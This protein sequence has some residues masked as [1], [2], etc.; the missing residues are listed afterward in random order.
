MSFLYWLYVSADLRNRGERKRS[1]NWPIWDRRLCL[2]FL[3]VLFTLLALFRL[4]DK[5]CEIPR[6]RA[7]TRTESKSWWY[8]TLEP[9]IFTGFSVCAQPRRNMQIHLCRSTHHSCKLSKLSVFLVFLNFS[10]YRSIPT[11]AIR[12]NSPSS[13]F[14]HFTLPQNQFFIL[15]SFFLKKK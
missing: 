11:S 10:R 14:Q 3:P 7:T 6:C 12:S 2:R 15:L 5:K 9:W 8:P 4:S 1:Y 13:S